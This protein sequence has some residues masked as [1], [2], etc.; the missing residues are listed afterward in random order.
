M[1][2]VQEVPMKVQ[3][4]RRGEVV[5]TRRRR[6]VNPSY[7][8]V[9][10]V[11]GEFARGKHQLQYIDEDGDV[12]TMSSQEEWQEC[13]SCWDGSEPLRIRIDLCSGSRRHTSRSSSS[14][15][16][17]ECTRRRRRHGSHSRRSRSP[18]HGRHP[19][20]FGPS[21]PFGPHFPSMFNFARA[22]PSAATCDAD[23][24]KTGEKCKNCDFETTGLVSGFCCRK[25]R[26]GESHGKRCEQKPFVAVDAEAKT[27]KDCTEQRARSCSSRCAEERA[28]AGHPFFLLRGCPV[29]MAGKGC[30]GMPAPGAKD[31]RAGCGGKGWKGMHGTG[32]KGFKGMFGGC[33]KG[34]TE[35]V[36]AEL[37]GQKCSNCDFETT[38]IIDSFCCRACRRGKGHGRRC[39]QKVSVDKEAAPQ[40]EKDLQQEVHVDEPKQQ[41]EEEEVM[42]V[43][44][45]A[46]GGPMPLTRGR[47]W[48]SRHDGKAVSS[49]GQKCTNCDFQ[50]TGIVDSFCCRGC[51]HGRG[52]G[53][54]CEQLPYEEQQLTHEPVGETEEVVE[55]LAVC[56]DSMAAAESE[57]DAVS[58]PVEVDAPSCDEEVV[59]KQEPLYSSQLA[60][61]EGMGFTITPEIVNQLAAVNGDVAS[62][63]NTL[64]A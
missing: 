30:K 44:A 33:G 17:S 31:V 58:S 62:V 56:D 60:Q 57:D 23:K 49:S 46:V 29:G 15:S 26:R 59:V 43:D 47:R 24:V 4:V 64:L 10:K 27:D 52:H 22:W 18:V 13:M 7:E 48:L 41:E 8:V 63:L 53:P 39:A 3:I 37:I 2:G 51:R 19:P 50:T 5:E 16:S 1:S 20:F 42:P 28:S 40:D 45:V 6:L 12:V 14:S 25:C 21:F 61:I 38:G 11:A 9:A 55:G 36:D 32:G 34:I 35:A 54:R